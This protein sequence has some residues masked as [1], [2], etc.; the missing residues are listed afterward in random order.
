[1]GEYKLVQE[2]LKNNL[3]E[4]YGYQ[5]VVAQ[6]QLE[7]N[8]Q[9]LMEAEASSNEVRNAADGDRQRIE[10]LREEVDLK[11]AKID[12]LMSDLRV[13]RDEI[14]QQNQAIAVLDSGNG[15]Q[16]NLAVNW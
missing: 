5:W 7:N 1:M 6:S 8:R 9:L 4:W 16:R 3:R 14:Q 12:Q 2:N 11:R 10:G 13:L 15:P